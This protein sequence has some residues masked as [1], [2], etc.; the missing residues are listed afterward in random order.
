MSQARKIKV[1]VGCNFLIKFSQNLRLCR[2]KRHF[3]SCTSQQMPNCVWFTFKRLQIPENGL[4]VK[5]L[6][7][8]WC[9]FPCELMQVVSSQEHDRAYH[10]LFES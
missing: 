3:F 9:S 2:K 10:I 5:S 8:V 1:I 4:F 6:G 7:A